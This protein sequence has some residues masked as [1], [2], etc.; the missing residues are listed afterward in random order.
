MKFLTYIIGLILVG[1]RI[2]G[3]TFTPASATAVTNNGFVTAVIVNN[4]G[5]GYTDPPS[6]TFTGGGGGTGAAAYSVISNGSVSQI[7]VTNAGFDY[8]SVPTVVIA[9]PGD[10]SFSS[11]NAYIT[12]PDSPSLDS[13][14]NQVTVEC[15]FNLSAPATDWTSLVSKEDESYAFSGYDL[16]FSLGDTIFGG[17][18]VQ[19]SVIL[20]NPL[21]TR[22]PF[23]DWHHCAMQ[24]D[25][26]NFSVWLDGSM[27]Y[28]TNDPSPYVTNS[29]PLSIGSQNSGFRLFYG[30]IDEV[31]VS[32]TIRYT[33][34]FN[35][36][37]RFTSDSNTVALYHFDEGGG[38]IVH[39][40]S[41]NGNDGTIFGILA[42]AWSTNIAVVVPE[43]VF[44]HKAVYVDFSNLI[45]GTNYQLQITTNLYGGTWS[46]FGAP[47]TATSPTMGYSNYFNVDDWSSLFFRLSP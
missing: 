4:G 41:G 47:F 39:D 8:S 46:N 15:W 11:G 43:S 28:S 35:P 23:P 26:T 9:S 2:Y 45:I 25:G 44:I 34:P 16:R 10:Y 22:V 3:Q 32:K 18:L 37:L 27:I 12:V 36:A 31:R 19:P 38:S 24:F 21:K 7:I 33:A 40:S 1:T 14:T 13:T 17:I 30:L 6:V 42:S 20:Q 5:S 29:N